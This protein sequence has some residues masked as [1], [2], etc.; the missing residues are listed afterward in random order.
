[1]IFTHYETLHSETQ[2]KAKKERFYCCS[3]FQIHSKV[4][5]NEHIS[6]PK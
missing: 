3:I 4:F 2:I 1:M 5:N 6:Y